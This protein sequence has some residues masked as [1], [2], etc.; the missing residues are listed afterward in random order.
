MK[1]LNVPIKLR[2]F[3]AYCGGN[4]SKYT[5][6][7]RLKTEEMLRGLAM[8]IKVNIYFVLS[9]KQEQVVPF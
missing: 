6:E 2:E 1:E 4:P 9:F 3:I 8:K 5:K 7:E